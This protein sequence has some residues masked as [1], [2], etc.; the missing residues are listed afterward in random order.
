MTQNPGDIKKGSP[1][2]AV[3]GKEIKASHFFTIGFGCIIGVGWIIIIGEWLQAA[4][5]LGSIIAF[6]SGAVVM[7]IIG[8]CYA[9]LATMMP[10]SG[11]EVAYTY[12]IYGL[13]SSYIIGWFLSLAYIASVSFEAVSAAWILNN[14]IGDFRGPLLYSIRGDGVYLGSLLF[15]LGGTLFLGFLNFR[16]IKEA[17]FFQK[18]TTYGLLLIAALFIPA[19]IIFGKT[20]NLEPLFAPEGLGP[21]FL[22][23]LG[24]FIV[25]PFMYSGFQ[26]IPQVMEEKSQKTSLALAGRTIF[27]SIAGA[28]IFYILVI[29][30]IS[31]VQP[32]QNM[33]GADLPAAAAFRAAFKSP[34][35]AKAVLLAGFLGIVTTWNSVFIAGSRV[36]FAFGRARIIPSAF[37]KIHPRFGTPSTAIL[38]TIVIA[39]CGILVGRSAILP[40]V[41]VAG[42]GYA[43]A[44][45]FSCLGVAKLR[46]RRPDLPRPYRAP[47]GLAL[48]IAGFVLSILMVGLTI[49]QPYIASPGRIPLEW[50]FIVIWTFLGILFWMWA[51]KIR[52]QVNEQERRDLIFGQIAGPCGPSAPKD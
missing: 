32:W 31:M 26:V 51:R 1:P 44:F 21:I 9:E 30:S 29:L 23:I 38:F 24:V 25:V 2:Q 50:I 52:Y 17:A 12:E 28:A 15:S 22:G 49:V 45:I 36:V 43:L 16:G 14:L 27:Y 41:N 40:I 5:P 6:A 3:L 48:P 10:V 39:S 34:L 19:G 47:G 35:V 13:K 42:G 20:G 4:G 18:L 33:M 37:S 11:G 7:M 8:F 46:R